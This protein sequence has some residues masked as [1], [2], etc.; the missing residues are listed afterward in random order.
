MIDDIA[1]HCEEHGIG[2][3]RLKNPKRSTKEDGCEVLIDPRRKATLGSVVDG[4]LESRLN[5]EQ[6]GQLMLAVRGTA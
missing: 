1:T 4:F 5:G 6:K 2:L 3:I